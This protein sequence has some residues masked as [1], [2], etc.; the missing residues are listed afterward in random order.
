MLLQLGSKIP[1]EL[2]YTG[3]TEMPSAARKMLKGANVRLIN[4]ANKLEVSSIVRVFAGLK[5][6]TCTSVD[7]VLVTAATYW[8]RM[9]KYTDIA[10]SAVRTSSASGH[11]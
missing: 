5:S 4:L 8:F 10:A 2:F 6:C 3:G 1:I 9:D 7:Y 11:H